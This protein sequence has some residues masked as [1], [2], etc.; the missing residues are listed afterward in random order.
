[1][2]FDLTT[3]PA[4]QAA[5]FKRFGIAWARFQK[6][7]L[8]EHP[9]DI[10][11]AGQIAYAFNAL[12]DNKAF[13]VL[14]L[15]VP[16]KLKRESQVPVLKLDTGARVKVFVGQLLKAVD[17]FES[18][19]KDP[20]DVAFF[21]KHDEAELLELMAMAEHAQAADKKTREAKPKKEKAEKP[22]ETKAEAAA[23]VEDVLGASAPEAAT[24]DPLSMGEAVTED[25]LNMAGEA[26]TTPEAPAVSLTDDVP[27]PAVPEKKPRKTKVKEE[28]SVSEPAKP[29][30]EKPCVIFGQGA[31]QCLK[32]QIPDLLDSTKRYLKHARTA[33]DSEDPFAMLR[34]GLASLDRAGNLMA[35]LAARGDLD[36]DSRVSVEIY[37]TG[38]AI[39]H[40]ARGILRDLEAG[41]EKGKAWDD[42]IKGLKGILKRAQ[43]P[44]MMLKEKTITDGVV[45]PKL[46]DKDGVSIENV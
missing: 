39:L 41:I 31:Y 30:E 13:P 33:G 12:A 23:A 10:A 26:P 40:D 24:E 17:A 5:Y 21:E 34:S 28:A 15:E 44:A 8:S 18:M 7:A 27:P 20:V 9:W 22:V 37:E 35:R 25:P 32:E 45:A 6:S 42:A 11:E 29:E 19:E 16:D 36:T 38:H 3:A 46:R 43:G 1:M 4:F 14:L 2:N